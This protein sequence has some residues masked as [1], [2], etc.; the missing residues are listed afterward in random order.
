M[1]IIEAQFQAL[2][3]LLVTVGVLPVKTNFWVVSLL[4]FKGVS[5]LNFR[6]Q[7]KSI[8]RVV[9]LVHLGQRHT[10]SYSVGVWG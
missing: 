10:T 2:Y 3:A 9:R 5:L 4:D 8:T 1:A 6:M 7:S